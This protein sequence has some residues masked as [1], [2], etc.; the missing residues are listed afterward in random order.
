MTPQYFDL[1]Y[2]KEFIDVLPIDLSEAGDGISLFE[3]EDKIVCIY[4]GFG[5]DRV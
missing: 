4:P 3:P 5:P 2:G 1:P